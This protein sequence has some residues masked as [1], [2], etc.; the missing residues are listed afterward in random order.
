MFDKKTFDKARYHEAKANKICAGCYREQTIGGNTYCESCREKRN[1]RCR[2]RAR[3][4]A[5]LA[6]A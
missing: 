2:E 3:V 5:R 4:K 6:R 1:T